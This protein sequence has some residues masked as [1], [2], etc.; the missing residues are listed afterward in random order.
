MAQAGVYSD[1]FQSVVARGPGGRTPAKALVVLSSGS[2]TKVQ[3]KLQEDLAV[4]SH[5][6]EKAMD[7]SLG[8][9]QRQPRAM[10]VDLF[11]WADAGSLRQAYLEGYGA[12]FL[13]KI[14]S[15]LLPSPAKDEAQKD[16]PKGS[17]AWEEA[18]EEVFGEPGP[19]GMSSGAPEEPYNEVK[20]NRLK[21]SILE[22]LKNATNIRDLKADEGV[23]VCVLGG[24]K[25]QSGR[26][27]AFGR[28]GG[29]PGEMA[30]LAGPAEGTPQRG[31]VLSLR[32]K[33]SAIDAF[34]KG[35]MDLDEFQKKALI[36]IYE[37]DSNSGPGFGGYGIGG[38]GGYGGG[39]GT[40]LR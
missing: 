16:E 9:D 21:G 26:V 6:L 38:V 30:W 35:Q 7:D 8:S 11:F 33:K 14:N 18:R 39:Y 31:T 34:A 32:V 13:L 15:P 37:A 2:D 22:A 40:G 25:M 5:I 4:M 3:G 29:K 10:G 28:A 17:S 20:V 36:T 27:K 24:T 12:L 1:R 19:I 23:T